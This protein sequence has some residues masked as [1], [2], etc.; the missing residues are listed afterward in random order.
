MR[1]EADTDIF[2]EATPITNVECNSLNVYLFVKALDAVV[3][4]Y[5]FL[6]LVIRHS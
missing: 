2:F 6:S 5:I 3:V 1:R 4:F